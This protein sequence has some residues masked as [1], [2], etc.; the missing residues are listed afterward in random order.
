ML[1]ICYA[2]YYHVTANR[3]FMTPTV[4]MK[5]RIFV[6]G[7]S[8]MC[9]HDPKIPLKVH[10]KGDTQKKQ[11]W[12]PC[13]FCYFERPESIQYAIGAKGG[14]YARSTLFIASCRCGKPLSSSTIHAHRLMNPYTGASLGRGSEKDEGI[15]QCSVCRRREIRRRHA[16]KRN[17]SVTCIRCGQTF[18]PKRADAKYCSGRCRTAACRCKE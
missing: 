5:C 6:T 15:S 14:M 1:I 8:G 9:E 12:R 10:P 17:L 16:A 4:L 11:V 18:V 3:H 7:D 13:L 2:K